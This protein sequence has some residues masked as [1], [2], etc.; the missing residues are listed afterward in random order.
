MNTKKRLIALFFILILVGC[1]LEMPESTNE[2]NFQ[3]SEAIESGGRPLNDAEMAVAL[4]VCY[5]LRSKRT[6]YLAELLETT[7]NFRIQQNDCQQKEI[8]MTVINSTLKQLESNGPMSFETVGINLPYQRQVITDL[9][10]ELTAVCSEVLKGETPLN[11]QNNQNE[12]YEYSYN[13]SLYDVVEI[14]IGSKLRPT[15]ERASVTRVLKLE[16]LTAQKSS[17][18]YLGMVYKSSL[19]LPCENSMFKS[20]IQTFIAP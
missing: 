7:F 2:V 10:G 19:F 5:A 4:R 15:D 14:K 16:I 12:I 3:F 18:D 17:G 13:S 9:H 20:R 8:T 6:N 11:L 1:G